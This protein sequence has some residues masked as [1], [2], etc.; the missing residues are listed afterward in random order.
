VAFF[1]LAFALTW[2]IM[3]PLVL[4][5]YGL[6]PFP[7]AVPLLIVMGYGATFAA[8]IVTG[9]LGG[10][11]AIRAL[12]GRLLIWRVGWRWWGVAVFLNAAIILGALGLYGLLGNAVPSFPPLVPSLLLDVVLTFVI[13]GL[14]NGEEIGWRGFAL[15]RLLECYGIVGALA[16]LGVLE[17]LYHLPIFFSNGASSAGGQNGTP[18]LA[19]TL[20]SILAVFLFTWLYTHTRGSLLIATVFHASMNAWTN[21]LPF[22][23]TSASFFWLLALVQLVV[24][25]IVLVAGDTGWLARW[26]AGEE[27]SPGSRGEAA[28]RSR[29]AVRS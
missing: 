20:S 21:I 11:P 27:A 15:P 28:E 19:F 12:L 9:A 7:D 1:V 26:P 10:R 25:V 13:V 23:S 5:S 4:S 29:V 18:F 22:P 8:V 17:T 2:A 6:F 16:V 24:V 3:I 14:V